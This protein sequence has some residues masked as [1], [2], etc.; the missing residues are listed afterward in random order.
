[1]ANRIRIRQPRRPHP[2]QTHFDTHPEGVAS[3]LL[4]DASAAFRKAPGKAC[5]VLGLV[6]TPFAAQYVTTELAEWYKNF[7]PALR[8]HF[9]RAF[10]GSTASQFYQFEFRATIS[11]D[12]P[13]GR[14]ATD[15]AVVIQSPPGCVLGP[16]DS[17]VSPTWMNDLAGIKKIKMR[18]TP[19]DSDEWAIPRLVKGERVD[20][21]YL[22][23]VCQAQ[24]SGTPMIHVMN[25]AAITSDKQL[26]LRDTEPT[27]QPEPQVTHTGTKHGGATHE[28]VS[29][30]RTESFPFQTGYFP[31][32]AVNR[33]AIPHLWDRELPTSCQPDSPCGENLSRSLAKGSEVF[34]EAA[35]P[36]DVD[37]PPIYGTMLDW[38]LPIE[39]QRYLEN[40]KSL[41]TA[42][43]DLAPA[44]TRHFG[45]DPA[46]D[47]AEAGL[48]DAPS[49]VALR[50]NKE[51]DDGAVNL[52]SGGAEM[53]ALDRVRS[54][55]RSCDLNAYSA[56]PAPDTDPGFVRA[57]ALER[58]SAY[59]PPPTARP[60]SGRSGYLEN[61]AAGLR[62]G[63]VR[64]AFSRTQTY[65]SDTAYQYPS[66]RGRFIRP[67][68][69]RAYDDDGIGNQAECDSMG[70]IVGT[71]EAAG[72]SASLWAEDKHRDK[73]KVYRDGERVPVSGESSTVIDEA[74]PPGFGKEEALSGR[75]QRLIR[76]MVS[77]IPG[78]EN[79][80]YDA[81]VNEISYVLRA[82]EE[83]LAWL[84]DEAATGADSDVALFE[85]I[86]ASR[87]LPY[88][89]SR[90]V[91][92]SPVGFTSLRV[93]IDVGQPAGK[94]LP[95]YPVSMDGIPLRG[96]YSS[97]SGPGT[98]SNEKTMWAACTQCF[99]N[100]SPARTSNAH[101]E[102]RPDNKSGAESSA[103]KPRATGS[104]RSVAV[105]NGP[106]VTYTTPGA[107]LLE[108][109]G[110]IHPLSAG[111]VTLTVLNDGGANLTA[112]A[113]SSPGK[114]VPMKPE[115]VR[116]PNIRSSQG[117][118]V[119]ILKDGGVKLRV[120]TY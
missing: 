113:N 28:P 24:P 72:T 12:D 37:R 82:T 109:I 80:G 49:A 25:H 96:R 10:S 112:T 86:E 116:L 115:D 71:L 69:H 55:A 38:R 97:T 2:S 92:P 85:A 35:A 103:D 56:Q 14:V 47:E 84:L 36:E 68:P 108:S 74:E 42:L 63:I 29:L 59:A 21:S 40:P 53:A 4:R 16:G 9:Q 83:K 106:A 17:Q 100:L 101:E 66:S 11:N 104:I 3:R 7:L 64:A 26:V 57:A 48:P 79:N 118:I 76:A 73:W 119:S 117:V 52:G 87:K 91:D 50:G 19:A 65:V 30:F 90:W 1:M 20:I 61:S 107:G 34:R 51:D 99:Q 98:I 27:S 33:P 75:Q 22:T 58:Y 46:P 95:A 54:S 93:P 110:A 94:D 23:V 5:A 78:G 88:P 44:E 13:F 120:R 70:D 111:G 67:S 60:A 89:G 105:A 102:K 81:D 39:A 41:T 114:E 8:S 31:M 43:L 6:L 18:P 32:L 62:G 45:F 15:V 77:E